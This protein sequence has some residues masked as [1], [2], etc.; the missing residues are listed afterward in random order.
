MGSSVNQQPD[1]ISQ[2]NN[3]NEEVYKKEDKSKIRKLDETILTSGATEM[4]S[5]DTLR[6]SQTR[7]DR[8]DVGLNCTCH[9]S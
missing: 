9:I 5:I 8:K 2:S 4:D 6:D 1:N 3:N 7:E